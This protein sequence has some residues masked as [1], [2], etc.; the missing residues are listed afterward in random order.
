VKQPSQPGQKPAP[1]DTIDQLL[2]GLIP[3]KKKPQPPPK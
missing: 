1:A 3:E 2:R